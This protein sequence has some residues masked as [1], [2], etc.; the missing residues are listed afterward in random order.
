MIDF[1]VLR[2]DSVHNQA[3]GLGTAEDVST[4]ARPTTRHRLGEADIGALYLQS[5]L[6]QR[7]V[8]EVVDDALAQGWRVY[9]PSGAQLDDDGQEALKA[10][11]RDAWV[12][13]RL[14]S[15]AGLLM[16]HA[17]TKDL[18]QPLSIEEGAPD[19][20][21]DFDR[22]EFSPGEYDLDPRSP[23]F[24]HP[25]TY[26]IAVGGEVV[27]VHH[28]RFLLFRGAPL[29]RRLRELNNGYD[30]SVI[31]AC[32]QR[33]SNFEQTELAMGNI[34]QRF[35]MG[36]YRIQGLGDTL[37]TPEQQTALL[38]R[39]QLMQTTASMVRAVV[40][41]KEMEDY[42]RSFT[43]V[44]GLDTIWD[45]LAHSVAKDAEEPMTQLFGM[46]PSGLATDD[47][48]GRANWRKK[49]KAEQDG[50][51]LPLLQRYYAL[52]HG[53][54]TTVVFN[55]LDESTAAERSTIEKNR[56]ETR[57]I[58]VETG[59]AD[60]SEFREALVREGVVLREEYEGLSPSDDENEDPEPDEE[61]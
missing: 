32:W 30:D 31:Q 17:K 25:L 37:E 18:S 2:A 19:S 28:S 55:P 24:R 49:V 5:K 12:S 27:K 36:V 10:Q 42:T 51:L 29:P 53:E 15:N 43:A 33:I 57:A 3:S 13:A 22:H 21:V 44:N 61:A 41:D 60:A 47:E 52:L 23:N 1:T 20:L 54:G 40:I 26:N 59:M 38:R 39:L 4:H 9:G 56:A 50:Q 6:T 48:S 34:V 35:E 11:I 7:I 14:W 58:Y 45:R 8:K 16:M 46:A